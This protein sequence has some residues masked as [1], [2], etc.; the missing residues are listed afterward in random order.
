MYPQDRCSHLFLRALAVLSLSVH[1][2]GCLDTRSILLDDGPGVL[3]PGPT[4]GLVAAGG[5]AWSGGD[6]QD[7]SR[8]TGTLV[9]GQDGGFSCA[10]SRRGDVHCWGWNWLGMLGDGTL[11]TQP[12][13][14]RV[15]GLRDVRMVSSGALHSCAL[16]GSGEV[17]CWG[18]ALA[19]GSPGDPCVP[20]SSPTPDWR[21]SR[22]CVATPARVPLPEAAVRV[23]VGGTLS[24]AATRS[25]DVYC[26]GT[27]DWRRH[28]SEPVLVQGGDP[29]QDL[30]VGDVHACVL[31]KGVAWCWG[32]NRQLQLGLPTA[33]DVSDEALEA[34]P[35][36]RFVALSAGGR[37][38]CGLTGD[39]RVFCWGLSP[40]HVGD[41]HGWWRGR[42]PPREVSFPGSGN[43]VA[44]LASGPFHDCAITT[45]GE[46]LCWGRNDAGQL[47]EKA[48]A[49][50]LA[51][52]H[53]LGSHGGY[54]EIAA[55]LRHTCALTGDGVVE[56]WGTR[57]RG[58]LGD[59]STAVATG[60]VEV[61]A[62]R[63]LAEVRAAPGNICART[64]EGDA[65]C[66]GRE[67]PSGAWSG[68]L[69]ARAPGIA[70]HAVSSGVSHACGVTSG[71][72]LVC[73][74]SNRFGQLGDGTRSD[75]DM[76]TTVSLPGDVAQVS[77]GATHSC[78]VTTTGEAYCWGSNDSGEVDPASAAGDFTRPQKV[79]VAASFKEVHAGNRSSCGLTSSGT[80]YC[81]G[82]NDRGQL[83]N[84]TDEAR[85]AAPVA[86]GHRFRALSLARAEAKE[87]GAACGLDLEGRGWCWGSNAAHKLGIPPGPFP[88]QIFTRAPVEVAPGRR[89]VALDVG[90][91][92]TC[93]LDASGEIECWGLVLGG[94][95]GGKL[96]MVDPTPRSVESSVRFR[97]VSV[98]KG[99]VCGV[100]EGARLFC[101]GNRTDGALGDGILDWRARPAPVAGFTGARLP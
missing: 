91:W 43:V 73:W 101:W 96:P 90:E 29:V 79:T 3:E 62:G 59:G 5:A 44:R 2:V 14:I 89:Y 15:A 36:L 16:T 6:M 33:G 71:R 19:A 28:W 65:Y 21:A 39:G 11:E 58:A 24:C 86:G 42:T 76:A 22:T 30:A 31:R 75:R 88:D 99:V 25:H 12:R 23:R 1:C 77:A 51:A 26:W 93:G 4:T 87:F 41:A 55:S 46:I 40:A 32:G 38:T 60:P 72:A 27:T 92:Q 47:G 8:G 66:W 69:G 10:V 82:A 98:G 70:L 7:E 49:S 63:F 97:T 48:G 56:C 57:S 100:A 61:L 67:N 80:A 20:D 94:D 85:G 83:G 37:H 9:P 53:P 95:F 34:A 68:V 81:W 50:H 17:F 18:S 52:V 78:A 74:G 13:P 45:K 54:V 35:G 64:T 84:G